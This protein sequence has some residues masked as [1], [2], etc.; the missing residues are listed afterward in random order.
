MAYP[1]ARR[2]PDRVAGRKPVQRSVNLNVRRALDHVDKLFLCALRMRVGR[3][4]PWQ[5][6]LMM[7]ADA[8]QVEANAEWS[9]DRRQFDLTRVVL[10]IRTFYTLCT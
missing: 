9:T 10:I 6:P 2:E 8:D 4:P 1:G 5:K 3:A 7:D